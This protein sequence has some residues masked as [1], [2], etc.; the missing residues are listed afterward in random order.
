M[1]PDIHKTES[2][3]S[4]SCVFM[5][6]K[7]TTSKVLKGRRG[8]V[9]EVLVFV[10]LPSSQLIRNGSESDAVCAGSND[11]GMREQKEGDGKVDLW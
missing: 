9:E 7:N 4:V 11:D 2:E 10:Y 5:Q 6:F 3:K 8:W 1:S